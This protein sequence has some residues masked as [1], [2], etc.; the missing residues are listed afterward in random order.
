[1]Q[2]QS[3]YTA[4]SVAQRLQHL[5]PEYYKGGGALSSSHS[6]NQNKSNRNSGDKSGANEN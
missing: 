3:Q 2:G 6:D 1:M 5:Q 4:I